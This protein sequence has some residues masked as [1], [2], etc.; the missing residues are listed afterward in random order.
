[1]ERSLQWKEKK[2]NEEM[3]EIE[4]RNYQQTITQATLREEMEALQVFFEEI[5]KHCLNQPS[6]HL[7]AF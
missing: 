7:Y 1:M 5:I 2:E 6:D 4:V 3:E